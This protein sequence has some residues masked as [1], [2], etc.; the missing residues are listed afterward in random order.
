MT[1][2]LRLRMVRI[3]G[4]ELRLPTWKEGVLPKTLYSHIW[5]RHEDLRPT[6]RFT[7]A[8][9]RYLCFSGIFFNEPLPLPLFFD[10]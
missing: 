3:R 7:R 8:V 6:F 10:L 4:F 1:A 2:I 5:S 9:H